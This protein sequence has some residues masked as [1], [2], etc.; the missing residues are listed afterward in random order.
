MKIRFQLVSTLL[1]AAL[2]AAIICGS[3]LAQSNTDM[4]ASE[5]GP[6]STADTRAV[7]SSARSTADVAALQTA[8]QRG[9]VPAMLTLARMYERGDNVEQDYARSNALYCR[10]AAR[11]N[12]DALFRLGQIYSTGRQVMPNERVGALLLHRAAELGHARAQELLPYVSRGVGAVVPECMTQPI[13]KTKAVAGA[14][15]PKVRKDIAELVQRWAPQYSVDPELVL[16]LI[17]VESNFNAGA[18][19]PKN[20]Q[21]LMQLIP[22]TAARFGVKNAFNVVENLK[23]GLAYLR[24]LMSYFKGDV[25]LVLAAYNAG[26]EA[27]E[28]YRGIPPYRETRDYVQRITNVY[29]KSSHP[30]EA[31]LVAPSGVAKRVERTYKP[32]L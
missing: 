15:A 20:A 30:Y 31:Q 27:V 18:V 6:E 12:A 28:R 5:P 10:A 24:W 9:D 11:G 32:S 16:A 22:A 8:A 17:G 3:A 4:A 14:Y 1:S 23:G 29:T 26:E 19:S 2:S 21:G 7:Q 25:E 13:E